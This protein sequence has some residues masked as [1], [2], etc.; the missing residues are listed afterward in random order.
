M[1]KS[2]GILVF[3]I[4]GVL[5]CIAVGITAV[6]ISQLGGNKIL[7]EYKI[8]S[9][10]LDKIRDSLQV[11]DEAC[12]WNVKG[13]YEYSEDTLIFEADATAGEISGKVV[14]NF[15]TKH[16]LEKVRFDADKARPFVEDGIQKYLIDTYG[17]EYSEIDK[18]TKRWTDGKLKIDM[19][20][21]D[22]KVSIYWYK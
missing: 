15:D 20:S 7:G 18:E 5:V 4:V 8:G 14:L 21:K 10:N 6:L 11:A 22:N 2:K 3:V 12:V 9:T 1:S 16:L 19:V 17:D 13:F